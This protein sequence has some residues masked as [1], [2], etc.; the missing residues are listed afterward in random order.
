MT[1]ADFWV[2]VMYTAA[3]SYFGLGVVIAIGGWFD[4]WRM[5]RRLSTEPPG[6]P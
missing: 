3:L 5:L 4:M 6:P 1:L 2:Y